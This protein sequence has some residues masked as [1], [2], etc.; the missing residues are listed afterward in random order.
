MNSD[1]LLFS[2]CLEILDIDSLLMGWQFEDKLIIFKIFV[3]VLLE[4]PI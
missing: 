3:N 4:F 2:I 1:W